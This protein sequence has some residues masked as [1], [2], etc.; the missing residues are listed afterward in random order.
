MDSGGTVKSPSIGGWWSALAGGGIAFAFY[1]VMWIVG[2]AHYGA[3]AM[4]YGV[5]KLAL[6]VG[7]ITGFPLVIEMMVLALIIGA[8]IS[9]FLLVTCLRIR[10]DYIPY[11]NFLIIGTILALLPGIPS[12]LDLEPSI[13]DDLAGITDYLVGAVNDWLS[14]L[15]AR[16]W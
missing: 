4:G 14:W 10:R 5:V 2:N 16:I 12:L 1:W 13:D 3:G 8:V 9:A 11:G 7:L 15:V 6:F